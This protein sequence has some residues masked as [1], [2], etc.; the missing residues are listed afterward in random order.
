VC[1][2]DAVGHA[3]HPDDEADQ[4]VSRS[5]GDFD[6]TGVDDGEVSVGQSVH[7]LIVK[8]RVPVDLRKTLIHQLE[9]RSNVRT[10]FSSGPELLQ[11]NVL[12]SQHPLV[13]SLIELRD[14]R[15]QRHLVDT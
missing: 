9:H 4:R 12:S 10:E 2:P 6:E 15:G 5:H 3:G 13:R 11:R 14:G 8:R 1:R 7:L